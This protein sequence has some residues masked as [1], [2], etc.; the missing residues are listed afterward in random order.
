[1]GI[2]VDGL[3]MRGT[4]EE[5]NTLEGEQ[6]L[7]EIMRRQRLDRAAA[8]RQ[9]LAVRS[10]IDEIVTSLAVQAIEI[11]PSV[12]AAPPEIMRS[13]PSMACGL[14]VIWTGRP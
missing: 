9:F 5:I 1:M 6:E 10:S 14:V 12:S 2:I 3:Q 8:E 11:Y 4:A 13:A 7:Q